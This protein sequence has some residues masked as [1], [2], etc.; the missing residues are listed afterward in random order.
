MYA[1]PPIPGHSC[2][3]AATFIRLDVRLRLHDAHNNKLCLWPAAYT[4]LLTG[5]ARLPPLS[6]RW[7][8]RGRAVKFGY[9]FA[10]GD[11]VHRMCQPPP[12]DVDTYLYVSWMWTKVMPNRR[13]LLVQPSLLVQCSLRCRY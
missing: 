4:Q 12:I 5:K 7:P 3:Y 9:H 2:I 13:V 8:L 11:G 6:R 1:R 10:D